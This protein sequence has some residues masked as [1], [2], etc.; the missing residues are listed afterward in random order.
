MNCRV[1]TYQLL[2]LVL[3]LSSPNS[4]EHLIKH[5]GATSVTNSYV[6]VINVTLSAQNAEH[7][8]ILG[9]CK[10]FSEAVGVLGRLVVMELSLERKNIS[11]RTDTNFD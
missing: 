8:L 11:W 4:G 9:F 5:I 2:Y 7:V 1:V 10:E 3:D 6:E